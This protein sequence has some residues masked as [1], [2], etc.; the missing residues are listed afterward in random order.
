MAA[1]PKFMQTSQNE[2]IARNENRLAIRTEN[3]RWQHP[4]VVELK[5]AAAFTVSFSFLPKLAILESGV[6]F[7]PLDD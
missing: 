1:R 4:E 5:F 6:P 3:G 2:T 7:S